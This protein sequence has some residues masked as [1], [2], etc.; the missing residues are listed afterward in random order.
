[1]GG[2]PGLE[3]RLLD[4]AAAVHAATARLTAT[5]GEFDASREWE[6][7]GIQSVG[8]WG[9]I[10]LGLPSRLVND[11]AVVAARLP[12]LPA[13]AAAFTE[14]ALSLDKVRTVAAVATA[15]SDA[16]FTSMARAGSVAQ[17][18]RICRAYARVNPKE[19]SQ[20][21]R[22][23]NRGVTKREL[24]DG[25]VRITA[26]LD[27]DEA[28]IVFAAIDTRVEDAW[29]RSNP[30]DD[31]TTAEVCAPDLGSRRADA[32]VELATEA[33]DLGPDP[34]VAGE[35]VRVNIH[36]DAA[37]LAGERPAGV[38]EL[39][40]VGPVTRTL[41]Q[42][43]LCDCQVTLTADLP[44]ASIDLG[45]TQRTVSRRQ[46][47]ALQRRDRGCRFP[48]C[49]MFRF[50]HAHHA[51]PWEHDGPTDMDN[52]ML[53][54]PTHH[55][56]FHEGHY[57]IDTLGGGQ[58]TFRTPDGRAIEPPPLK[59]RPD[60]APP[61]PGNPRAE[62]GGERFDLDLAL[63]ALLSREAPSAGGGPRGEQ[64]PR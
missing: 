36:V 62:G 45:R 37:V 50:L 44:H 29:R 27:P 41:V 21:R 1:M 25:L 15:A 35:H 13:L 55:R 64:A 47:R 28:A 40:G 3:Q 59:A 19:P 48:G 17:L 18:Q 12:E 63:D 14:G 60:A 52:L 43:L 46:R 22:D 56:L 49:A 58:F 31:E 9:D 26:T 51:V 10:N 16:T 34:I 7:H 23:T 4:D 38:C 57:T 33:C 11:L 30:R 61:A 20:E 6:G 32:L 54:C 39:D 2:V 5:L 8:H 42:R 24:D 53:L